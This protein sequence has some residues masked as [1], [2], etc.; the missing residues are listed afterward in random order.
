MD[1]IITEDYVSFEIAKLLKEK[2]F[3]QK[4]DI[5]HGFVYNEKDYEHE[6]EIQR[7]VLQKRTVKA[8]TL[9]NYPAGIPDPKC[10]CPTLQMAMKWLRVVHKII[11]SFNASFANSIEQHISW[12]IRINSLK[13][14]N[15]E[16]HFEP[17]YINTKSEIFEEACEAAI[18]YCLEN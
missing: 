7:M 14:L 18:K 6:Y 15:D 12:N 8:G 11:I 2:G 4:Y 5:F 17:I 1:K 16:E 13:S 10:F 3:P 9:S